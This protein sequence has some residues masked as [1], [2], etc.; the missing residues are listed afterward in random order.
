[1]NVEKPRFYK[2]VDAEPLPFCLFHDP[3]GYLRVD[4]NF[5]KEG[6]EG[7][8]HYVMNFGHSRDS[9][10]I[11]VP[12]NER[13]T[14][15]TREDLVFLGFDNPVV[16]EAMAAITRLV[17]N[18]ARSY[19]CRED[20]LKYREYLKTVYELLAEEVKNRIEGKEALVFPPKNG[21][22]FVQEVCEKCGFPKQDFFDYRM[23]RVLMD[24]D[25]GLML[26]IRIGERNPKIIDY[27]TFVIADDCL[28]SDISVFGT[29]EIIKMKLLEASI[30]PSNTDVIIAVSAGTQRGLESLLSPESKDYFGFGK[31]E[32]IAGVPVFQMTDGFYLLDSKGG[33]RVGD[34]GKYTLGEE[35]AS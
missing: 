4:K 19:D 32:A 17:N 10:R 21:G 2:E 15:N 18:P 8:Y 27:R 20:R 11:E 31:I 26:G 25:E 30:S 1:M 6:S 29:L 23:S 3:E 12:P 7:P 33:Y 5:I 35:V 13:V 22:I 28:A 16:T 24:S 14:A 34:M 9:L